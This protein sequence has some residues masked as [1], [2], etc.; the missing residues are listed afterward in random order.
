VQGALQYS[1]AARHP[2]ALQR[3]GGHLE[4]SAARVEA[5]Y[6]F[7]VLGVGGGTVRHALRTVLEAGF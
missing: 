2:L 1:G 4:A 6:A 7:T 3:V 5:P